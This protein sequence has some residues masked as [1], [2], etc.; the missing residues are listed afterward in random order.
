MDLDARI[1]EN[2]DLLNL[3]VGEEGLM[4]FPNQL[5]IP[6]YLL[7]MEHQDDGSFISMNPIGYS[8]KR[9]LVDYK[10]VYKRFSDS[11]YSGFNLKPL[12]IHNIN[13]TEIDVSILNGG[14]IC[15]VNIIEWDT[16]K[17]ERLKYA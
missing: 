3:W 6:G 15:R 9:P 4:V 8:G 12:A 13:E 14:E 5:R 7:F 1:S 16:R 10:F 17:W 11:S 2:I